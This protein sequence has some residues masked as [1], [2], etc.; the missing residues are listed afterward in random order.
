MEHCFSGLPAALMPDGAHPRILLVLLLSAVASLA[1]GAWLGQPVGAASSASRPWLTTLR[2]A[3]RGPALLL[4]WGVGAWVAAS[5]VL[6]EAPGGVP[7]WALALA[8]TVAIVLL[9]W[10]FWRWLDRYETALLPPQEQAAP[11]QRLLFRLG[12][13]AV[14]VASSVM[15]LHALGFPVA[16]ILVLLAVAGAT[17]GFAARD[18][19]AN[20]YGGVTLYLDRPF[21]NGDWIRVADRALEGVVEHIGWRSTRVRTL[22]QTLLV[23][24]NATFTAA[25]V[26][27]LT[28]RAHFRLYETIRL[29]YED[30]EFVPQIVAETRRLLES[31]PGIDAEKGVVVSFT[32][33]GASSVDFMIHAFVRTADWAV[34]H[35][36]R[37]DVLLAIAEIVGRHGAEMACPTH[38][39][40]VNVNKHNP[41]LTLET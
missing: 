21:Y 18:L 9:G 2:S 23:V 14:F 24:P 35:A 16:G 20:V 27:N 22:E 38:N 41:Y 12:R 11:R 13:V 34:Y 33:F 28:R 25:G 29:R 3:S 4:I 37:Q 31:Y 7:P 17:L 6:S 19:L 40:N 8:H 32:G 36:Q 26:E 1:A 10:L 39:V 15:V 5:L 30:L